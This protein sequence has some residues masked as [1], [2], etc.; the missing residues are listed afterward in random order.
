VPWIRQ[1][2]R[3]REPSTQGFYINDQD[4][5]STAADVRDAF[6]QNH[7]R[8]VEVKNRYDPQN[9]FRLNANVQPTV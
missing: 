8:L 7:D 6:R 4:L 9:L 5:D 1:F 3:R 2:R